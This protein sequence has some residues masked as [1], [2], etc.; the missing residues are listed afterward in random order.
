ME[1]WPGSVLIYLIECGAEPGR[2]GAAAKDK[3]IPDP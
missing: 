1:K 2:D 3:P